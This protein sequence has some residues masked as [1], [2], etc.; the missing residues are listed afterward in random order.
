MVFNSLPMLNLFIICFG[1]LTKLCYYREVFEL[2]KIMLFTEK[3]NFL[4]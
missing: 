2:I 3:I 1:K 4:Y